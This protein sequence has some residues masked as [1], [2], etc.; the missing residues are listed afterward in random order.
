LK[1]AI[2]EAFPDVDVELIKSTGGAFEIRHEQDLIY[3][4]LETE[5]FPD[6]KDVI[7]MLKDRC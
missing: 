6:N 2:E 4:K 5:R 1:E 7:E 3:S